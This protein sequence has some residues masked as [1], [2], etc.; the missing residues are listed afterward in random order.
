M[1]ISTTN[2][3]DLATGNGTVGPFTFTF[4]LQQATDMNVY[5]SG[6]VISQ[7]LYTITP[8][9]G[10]YPCVGGSISWNLLAN[11]PATGVSIAF[12]S[13]V[14]YTQ[15]LSLPTETDF[16]EKSLE[17]AIDRNTL[18]IQQLKLLNDL[19]LHFA[20]TESV[21][22]LLS[23]QQALYL[24]RM[25][26]ANN[27]LEFVSAAQIA[28]E[29]TAGNGNVVGP[30]TST[31][32]RLALW[33]NA[34][35]TLLKDG[36]A[37]GN[38]G[39]VL[40]SQGPS[41]DPVFATASAGIGIFKARLSLASGVKISIT[42]QLAKTTLYL[43]GGYIPVLESSVTVQKKVN[44]G[45]ISIAITGT[46]GLPYDV[47][48]YDNDAGGDV[49]TLALVAWTNST[50]RATALTY[51]ADGDYYVHSGNNRTYVGTITPSA[52]NQCEDSTKY[53]GVWSYAMQEQRPVRAV[54]AANAWAVTSTTYTSFA[55]STAYGVAKVHVTVGIAEKLAQFSV[56]GEYLYS[57][58]RTKVGVGIDSTTVN[59]SIRQNTTDNYT[60]GGHSMVSADYHGYLS[61][62]AHDIWAIEALQ[63][64]ATSTTAYGDNAGLMQSGL[65]GTVYC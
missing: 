64:G 10:S 61:V 58:S 42:D 4:T 25:N 21:N 9:G 13:A 14:T 44:A 33:N 19:S 48:A 24:P 16:P 39:Q 23:G 38:A 46:A 5:V 52:T 54:N 17:N 30:A 11:A 29:V 56:Q 55:G 27:A 7:G 31:A 8:N 41:A 26:A 22:P 32:R 43:I 53:R 57:A 1:T 18:Q 34:T 15:P 60:T 36:P 37:L 28:N 62:G 2:S 63:T 35:G 12:A 20:V 3:R 51:V 45:Q 6:S 49:D 47:F 65:I 59:S 50:T 40:T